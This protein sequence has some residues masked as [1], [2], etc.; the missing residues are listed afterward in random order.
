MRGS[1]SPLNKMSDME[2]DPSSS[3]DSSS[4]SGDAITNASR[5]KRDKQ[6]EDEELSSKN[7]A[8]VFA[9]ILQQSV[10]VFH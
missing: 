8:S 1:Q 10:R 6:A 5:R 3:A 4:G 9:D 7:F 2:D